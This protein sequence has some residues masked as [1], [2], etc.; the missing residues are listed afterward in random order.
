MKA[1]S[2]KSAHERRKKQGKIYQLLSELDS[3]I[4]VAHLLAMAAP[5][6]DTYPPEP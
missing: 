4:L 2:T 1:R 3:C 5:T 6:E